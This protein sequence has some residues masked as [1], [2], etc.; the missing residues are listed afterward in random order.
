M[1]FVMIH[2][3]ACDNFPQYPQYQLIY[4]LFF[5]KH[6]QSVIKQYISGS[7]LVLKK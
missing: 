2:W 5:W 6:L 1:S 4:R 7:F 3:D